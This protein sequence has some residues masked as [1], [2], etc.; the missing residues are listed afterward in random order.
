M[1]VV[2]GVQR[3]IPLAGVWG[4]PP[5]ILLPPLLEERGPG[6]EVNGDGGT[7]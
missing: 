3:D 7:P 6:G 1:T 5:A 2:K 4:C